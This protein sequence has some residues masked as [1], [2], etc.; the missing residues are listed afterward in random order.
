MISGNEVQYDNS[1]SH[2][3]GEVFMTFAK[4]KDKSKLVSAINPNPAVMPIFSIGPGRAGKMSLRVLFNEHNS[5]I[6]EAIP[7][8]L[9]EAQN[10][11]RT[12]S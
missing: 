9:F 11:R 4:L 7:H 3:Q 12:R 1:I 6:H 8:Q 10:N 5:H 2:E